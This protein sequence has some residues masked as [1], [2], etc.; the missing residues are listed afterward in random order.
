MA[1]NAISFQA[2]TLWPSTKDSGAARAANIPRS[3]A[4]WVFFTFSRP[5]LMAVFSRTQPAECEGK[6]QGLKPRAQSSPRGHGRSRGFARAPGTNVR[7][8]VPAK[9]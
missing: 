7:E 3:G 4:L 5:A 1:V 2:F 9:G 6:T 8:E